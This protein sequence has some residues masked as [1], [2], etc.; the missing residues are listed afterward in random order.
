M[1]VQSPVVASLVPRSAEVTKGVMFSVQRFISSIY[2]ENRAHRL[3]NGFVCE[4]HHKV[5]V[6]SL[7][8]FDSSM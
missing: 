6:L 2:H 5:S 1:R 4:G 8:N 3:M 7:F